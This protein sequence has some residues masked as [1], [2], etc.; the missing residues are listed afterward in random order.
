MAHPGRHTSQPRKLVSV[1][2]NENVHYTLECNKKKLYNNKKPVKNVNGK[3]AQ[4]C[5]AYFIRN[6]SLKPRDMVNIAR[7]A[8]TT[9]ER[10]ASPIYVKLLGHQADKRHIHC[11]T[12][13]RHFISERI[14][15]LTKRCI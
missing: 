8:E 1:N 11:P 6:G 9:T 5:V 3:T 12:D 15:V 7:I 4:S 14:A 10:T 13:Q 2:E